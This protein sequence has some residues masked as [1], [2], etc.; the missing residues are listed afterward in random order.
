[1]LSIALASIVSIIETLGVL[2][3][4]TFAIETAKNK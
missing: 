2:C 1:L 3:P 4:F